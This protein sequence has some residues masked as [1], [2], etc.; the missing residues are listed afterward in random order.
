MR[1]RIKVG[2]IL[3]TALL[4]LGAA[5][6]SHALPPTG[7]LGYTYA[8]GSATDGVGNRLTVL[9]GDTDLLGG[10]GVAFVRLANQSGPSILVTFTCTYLNDARGFDFLEANGLGV[11][12]QTYYVGVL[13]DDGTNPAAPYDSMYTQTTPGTG[14]CGV[15]DGSLYPQGWFPVASGDFVVGPH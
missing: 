6:P 12:G 9:A 11:D 1:N 2:L 4:T 14:H 3:A 10:G 7:L 13:D 15:N 8:Y 5:S